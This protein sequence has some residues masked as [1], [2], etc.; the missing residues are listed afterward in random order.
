MKIAKVKL[1]AERKK[2]GTSD[3]SLENLLYCILEDSKIQK[4][5]FHGGAMNGVCCRRFLDNLDVIF[6][7]IKMLAEDRLGRNSNPKKIDSDVLHKVIDTFHHL[8]EVIDLVF[9]N[10]CIL[11]PTEIEI[12]NTEKSIKKLEELWKQMDLSETPKIHL[13]FVHAMIQIRDFGGIADLVEDFVEKAHQAGKKLDHLVARMSSQSFCQKELT[14]IQRQWI[15]S[16]PDVRTQVEQVRTSNK[17]RQS[18]S[19]TSVTKKITKSQHKKLIKQEKRR[20]VQASSS[21]VSTA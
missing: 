4:Q 17:R 20:K 6:P 2:R 3:E 16:D 1:D 10:M 13:L 8:F 11:C 7:K 9:S 15:V 14:K 5:H 19:S 21:T 12:N 18:V